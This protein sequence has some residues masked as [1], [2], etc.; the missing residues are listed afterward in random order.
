MC[1]TPFG[2]TEYIGYTRLHHAGASS[3][4]LNAFRHH[5]I[6]RSEVERGQQRG[7]EQ[8][9]NAFRHHGIYRKRLEVGDGRREVKCST[10][11]GITEYIGHDCVQRLDHELQCSTP[12]GITEYIG[13]APQLGH[14]H[15]SSVLNAF[16]HHG[17]YRLDRMCT[18]YFD[19]K[20]STPFGITEYIGFGKGAWIQR[21][22]VCSTPFG[23]TEYI[24]INGGVYR[25]SLPLVLNAFRHH[26]IYRLSSRAM[27]ARVATKCSTPFGITEYIGRAHDALRQTLETVLNAFRHHGIYRTKRSAPR[28]R[29]GVWRAQRLSASRNISDYD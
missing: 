17:I 23:I 4:V 22:Y 8:V 13:L 1:S 11:F 7:Q 12:F 3:P 24:G 18:G 14:T 28:K 20:C 27:R 5:G 2:I 10:P 15:R 26:G 9:L 16:R 19:D 29:P 25:S 21:S 6:Y